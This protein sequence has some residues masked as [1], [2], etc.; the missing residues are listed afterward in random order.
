ML[1]SDQMI[2]QTQFPGNET[3]VVFQGLTL[4]SYFHMKHMYSNMKLKG[5]FRTWT[6]AFLGAKEG[7]QEVDGPEDDQ[8]DAEVAHPS[9]H[10][11]AEAELLQSRH[12]DIQQVWMH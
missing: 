10:V 1:A 4:I 5:C 6:F 8:A 12:L 7:S 9:W 2:A 3:L 11:H